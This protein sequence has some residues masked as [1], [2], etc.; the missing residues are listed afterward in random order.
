Q[1]WLREI[2]DCTLSSLV[3]GVTIVFGVSDLGRLL[4]VPSSGYEAYDLE[5]FTNSTFTYKCTQDRKTSGQEH[6]DPIYVGLS[7]SNRL[8]GSPVGENMALRKDLRIS[9]AEIAKL[10][11]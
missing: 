4:N 11:E 3:H 1:R 8:F 7:T 6:I 9:Q 5:R 2:K 10:K